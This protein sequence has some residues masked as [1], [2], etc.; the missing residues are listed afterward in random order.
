MENNIAILGG[1]FN[2]VHLGHINMARAVMAE[3]DIARV[4]FL[5][6]ANPP[7]KDAEDII[8]A[9]HRYNMVKLAIEGEEGFELSDYEMK[10]GKPSYTVNTMRY[11]RKHYKSEP[12]FI[13]GA[14]SLYTLHKWKNYNEL[15]AECKFIVA[16]RDCI[17]GDDIKKASD[18]INKMGG[19]IKIMSM[20]KY[21]ISSTQIRE[22]ISN[23]LDMSAY[24]PEAVEAYIRE[25]NLYR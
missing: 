21:N 19:C 13:I 5:P 17:E 8:P 1:S 9:V 12:F 4:V 22:G 14:D 7:H 24:L 18:K 2:P 10:E 6:N 15:I 11:M 20:P 25:N 23:G 3:F 16:D